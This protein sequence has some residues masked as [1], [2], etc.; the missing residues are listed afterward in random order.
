MKYLEM[1]RREAREKK[2]DTPLATTDR[3]DRTPPPILPFPTAAL[4]HG[5]PDPPPA[6]PSE[7]WPDFTADDIDPALLDPT[8]QVDA[9]IVRRSVEEYRRF[10]GNGGAV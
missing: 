4:P 7:P 10:T 9:A 3:T 5:E 8:A 1:L 2:S 6:V